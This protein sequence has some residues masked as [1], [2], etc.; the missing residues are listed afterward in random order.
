MA[1][2]KVWNIWPRVQK[3]SQLSFSFHWDHWQQ[4]R[5]FFF[6][7]RQGR[8]SWGRHPGL[9]RMC[10][11]RP[12]REAAGHAARESCLESGLIG[13]GCAKGKLF[14]IC[15]SHPAANEGGSS[16]GRSTSATVPVTA[17]PSAVTRS[18]M[19]RAAVTVLSL[20]LSRAVAAA[21]SRVPGH[22]SA[23]S[24]EFLPNCQL[25]VRPAK[26]GA[27]SP[28]LGYHRSHWTREAVDVAVLLFARISYEGGDG[29]VPRTPRARLE[30]LARL[31]CRPGVG[32]PPV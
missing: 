2:E 14:G 16:A 19:A 31:S 22:R 11:N 13:G 6:F 8:E 26:V 1:G 18:L 4:G 12:S 23:P 17:A 20:P 32:T 27:G 7:E 15:P 25:Y 9:I 30:G 29:D 28:S 3:R 10:G 21:P 5:E 24:K